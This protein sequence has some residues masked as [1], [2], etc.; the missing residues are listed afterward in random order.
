MSS[1]FRDFV[2]AAVLGAALFALAACPPPSQAQQRQGE[3]AVQRPNPRAAATPKRPK[4]CASTTRSTAR[5]SRS[6]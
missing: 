6:S 2:R 5:A 4:A 3:A 1:K